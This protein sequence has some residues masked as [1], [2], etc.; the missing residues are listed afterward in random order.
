MNTNGFGFATVQSTAAARFGEWPGLESRRRFV[1]L[2]QHARGESRQVISTRSARSMWRPACLL[3]PLNQLVNGRSFQSTVPRSAR[4]RYPRTTAS[5][6]SRCTRT[7]P[8]RDNVELEYLQ[9][10]D[11]RRLMRQLTT[12]SN[13]R[14]PALANFGQQIVIRLRPVYSMP[15]APTICHISDEPPIGGVHATDHDSA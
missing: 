11:Q 4:W 10:L 12:G 3:R 13:N 9:C 14:H 2:C 5:C 1:D 8:P 15:P 6:T 7:W